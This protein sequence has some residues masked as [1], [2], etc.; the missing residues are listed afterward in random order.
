M[1]EPNRTEPKRTVCVD[2]HARARA[3]NTRTDTKR[4]EFVSVCANTMAKKQQPSAL[5]LGGRCIGRSLPLALAASERA[6]L[7]TA[8]TL[9]HNGSLARMEDAHAHQ[10]FGLR[11]TQFNKRRS[12]CAARCDSLA[13]NCTVRGTVERCVRSHERS[14][15]HGSCSLS[16]TSGHTIAA[17]ESH[18]SERASERTR[19][20]RL[21]L[22]RLARDASVLLLLL[23]ALLWSR[24][25]KEQC[26][27]SQ[28]RVVALFPAN[29]GKI[30]AAGAAADN[31]PAQ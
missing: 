21:R 28:L 15:S 9:A 29:A 25:L 5:V 17:I 7:T 27:A 31:I 18:E 22:V 8:T 30:P 14:R 12:D 16:Y 10:P 24:R 13:Q 1:C 2:E 19:C 3:Q 11:R 6:S 4:S 26:A 23:L 20:I